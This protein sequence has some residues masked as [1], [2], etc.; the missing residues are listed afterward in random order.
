MIPGNT[1][2]RSEYRFTGKGWGR[3]AMA[4]LLIAL[5][6]CGD[7]SGK[8][9][10][11][12]EEPGVKGAAQKG[13]F[14]MGG[15]AVAT[16]LTSEGDLSEDSVQGEITENGGYSL[17]LSSIAW[18]GPTLLVL[19]GTY[20]DETTANFSSESRT[21]HATIDVDN[22]ALNANVNLY[23]HF[24]AARVRRLMSD[25]DE[26]TNAVS[27]AQTEL[28]TLTGIVTDPG[29][30]DLLSAVPEAEADSANLLLFSAASLAAG[31]DQPSL[32]AIADD[33]ADDGLVN[34]SGEAAFVDVQEAAESDPG[35]LGDARLALQNQYSTEP[36]TGGAGGMAWMLDACTAATL[37]EP[38]V[39]CEGLDFYGNSFDDSEAFVTF[40]PVVSGHY[41]VELF[42]DPNADDDNTGRCSWTVYREADT[43]ASDSGDS[44]STDGW[45]GVED[46]TS[47]RLTGEREY[48][49]RPVV[50][51]DDDDGP[52][53][54]FKLSVT[55]VADGRESAGGAVDIP[56]GRPFEAVVGT[57]INTS[58]ESFYRFDIPAGAQ[59]SYTITA[60]GY[61]CGDGE[62]ELTL[63]E[64]AFNSEVDSAREADACSQSLTVPL[65]MGTYFLSVQ[66]WLGSWNRTTFRPA[67]AGIEFD[68][69]VMPES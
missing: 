40:I 50:S 35:L 23:T 10:N 53:A 39:M 4:A 7:S 41:T 60:G 26:F 44:G 17:P 25:G 49:V 12:E 21:L 13:P 9:D 18:S 66:N 36:P 29:E 27:Q 6:A 42:G 57:L 64:D 22:G 47:L 8:G 34:G 67:P 56:V 61:P 14:Q 69:R 37:T 68:L 15:D 3:A 5:T 32:D 28:E 63:Y 20:F 65:Q 45:C 24:K 2:H 48:F 59:G 43:S 33:F 11:Q 30:L 52:I 46:V 1:S 38:R 55:R 31:L 58:D 19:S 16:R 54:Q 62:L 51:K